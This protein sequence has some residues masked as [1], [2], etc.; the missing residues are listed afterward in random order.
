MLF[1]DDLGKEKNDE[2][3]YLVCLSRF[4]INLYQLRVYM[5][6]RDC[7]Y[8]SDFGYKTHTHTHT[9]SEFVPGEAEI[10]AEAS[11]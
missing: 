4:C 10:Q 11:F 1:F 2:N 8:G 7:L 6:T 5:K 9:Y 3:K